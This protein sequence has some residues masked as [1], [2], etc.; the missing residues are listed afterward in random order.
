MLYDDFGNG[1]KHVVSMASITFIR[2]WRG[3]R[4]QQKKRIKRNAGG[5]GYY[6]TNSLRIPAGEN[7]EIVHTDDVRYVER[8]FPDKQRLYGQTFVVVTS[9]FNA[10]D[11]G[12]RP[13]RYLPICQVTKRK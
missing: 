4:V 6:S 2:S 5:V 11:T 13:E 10:I 7:Y 9:E 8:M 3:P 12:R 1:F